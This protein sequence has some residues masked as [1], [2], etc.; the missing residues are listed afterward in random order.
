MQWAAQAERIVR[1]EALLSLLPAHHREEVTLHTYS[2]LRAYL[3][4]GEIFEGGLA[5]WEVE[6]LEHPA[7]PRN[8]RVL[9]AGAGGGRE[10][11]AL[12]ERGYEIFAFEPSVVLRT[13]AEEVASRFAG[14]RCVHG[15]YAD[16]VRAVRGS[17][18]LADAPW[19]FDLVYFGW[20]SFTHLL[21]S[22]EQRAVLAAVRSL[23]PNAP[24]LLSFWV[25]WH[26]PGSKTERA[27]GLVRR[28]LTVVRGVAPAPGLDFDDRAGF[29]HCFER[30]EFEALARN[31]GYS[32]ALFEE[33][34]F[35][36]AILVPASSP[37]ATVSGADSVSAN[38]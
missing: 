21:S 1:A 35:P 32:V 23:A 33:R 7:T 4:G 24:L 9:L 3:P 11:L 19:P 25:R 38:E 13:G 30:P 29:G 22:P 12:G 8:G 26:H 16:I 15:S 18:P 27:R 37:P 28:A 34:G 17:G 6:L 31:A 10:I 2:C 14:S 5:Q 20:G 36:H